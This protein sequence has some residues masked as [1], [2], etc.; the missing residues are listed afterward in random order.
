VS[1]VV[2]IVPVPLTETI[3]GLPAAL[4]VNETVPVT[5]PV[6]FGVSV[7]LITQFAAGVRSG[8]QLLVSAKLALALILVMVSVAVPELVSVTVRGWLAVPSTASPKVRLFGEKETLGEPPPIDPW[9]ADKSP[10][11]VSAQHQRA[12]EIKARNLGFMLPPPFTR[13]RR[14]GRTTW[15]DWQY[16]AP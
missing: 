14:Q 9:V 1:V 6:V 16:R 5:L 3:C 12:A 11:P 4:S 13:G 15:K 10:Q 7:T 2:P 8:P